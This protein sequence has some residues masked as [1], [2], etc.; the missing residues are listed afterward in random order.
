MLI[1]ISVL[2]NFDFSDTKK[3]VD[4]SKNLEIDILNQETTLEPIFVTKETVIKRNDSLFTILNKFG[5]DK[6]NIINLINSKNSNLL[7]NIEI[8]DKIRV[9]LDENN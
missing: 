9:N 8:G 6:Q 4:L 5:V 1:G 2:G 3:D 7:S